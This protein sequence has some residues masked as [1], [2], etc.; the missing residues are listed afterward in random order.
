MEPVPPIYLIGSPNDDPPLGHLPTESR[1]NRKSRFE[2]RPP[3]LFEPIWSEQIG[4]K[5]GSL[6]LRPR[7][8]R[9]VSL[10]AGQWSGREALVPVMKATDLGKGND[11]PG[12]HRQGRSPV[13]CILGQLVIRLSHRNSGPYRC[14][15]WFVN[16]APPKFRHK[17]KAAPAEPERRE[18]WVLG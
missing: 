17:K 2:K 13:W 12:T 1:D 10:E 18:A 4:P 3:E 9:Q 8:W 6:W 11:L 14:Y 15:T 5:A 16:L 7:R